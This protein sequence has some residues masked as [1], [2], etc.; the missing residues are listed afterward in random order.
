MLGETVMGT[1]DK[2][3]NWEIWMTKE[4]NYRGIKSMCKGSRRLSFIDWKII[5]S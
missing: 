3:C 2:L 5:K 1:D 4:N